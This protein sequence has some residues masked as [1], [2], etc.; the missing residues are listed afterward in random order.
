MTALAEHNKT[1]ATGL[2]DVRNAIAARA[3]LYESEQIGLKSQ[4]QQAKPP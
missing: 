1:L 4:F 2:V 3:D